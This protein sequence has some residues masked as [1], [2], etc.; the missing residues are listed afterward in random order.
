MNWYHADMPSYPKYDRDLVVKTYERLQNQHL[1]AKELGMIQATVS[2]ILRSQGIH[3]GK[4][5]NRQKLNLPMEEV[6]RRYQAGEPCRTIAESFAVETEALRRRL[7][8]LGIPRRVG[9]VSGPDNKQWKGGTEDAMHYFRRQVYEVAAIC[10]G[11]PLEQG[12]VIHHIDENKKHN[13]PDNL[14][15]FESLSAHTRFHQRQLALQVPTGSREAIQLALENGARLL[16]SPPNPLEFLR[17]TDQP[18]PSRIWM[19]P[20]RPPRGWRQPQGGPNPQL[21]LPI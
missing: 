21:E 10:L 1:V 20:G 2:K 19:K 3:V 6:V 8:R 7:V 16:P 5:S 15:I 12:W 4:G 14:M 18:A 9:G 11:R 13:H 17:C